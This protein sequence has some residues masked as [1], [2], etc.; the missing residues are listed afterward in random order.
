MHHRNGL[1]DNMVIKLLCCF[2]EKKN[3]WFD[4]FF[5]TLPFS[6]KKSE[7]KVVIR[8]HNEIVE[9]KKSIEYKLEWLRTFTEYKVRE[10]PIGPLF[11]A[12]CVVYVRI[13]CA[14]R[15]KKPLWRVRRKK[16]YTNTQVHTSL[17]ATIWSWFLILDS[18]I[19]I[20]W[21]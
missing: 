18:R 4:F 16:R 13:C 14:K 1:V 9:E 10:W 12:E 21:N 20:K 2:V 15:R 8:T 5:D 17:A 7:R 19:E 6:R 3:P 11:T